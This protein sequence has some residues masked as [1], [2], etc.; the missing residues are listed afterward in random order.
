MFAAYT[1]VMITI[2]GEKHGVF[3]KNQGYDPTF[4]KHST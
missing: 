1:P 4:A 2:F 3:I